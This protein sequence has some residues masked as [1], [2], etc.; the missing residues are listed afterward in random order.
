MNRAEVILKRSQVSL[1]NY[2]MPSAVMTR[3]DILRDLRQLGVSDGDMLMVH[4]SMK[5]IGFVV[6]G[7][8]TLLDS[9]V[10]AVGPRGTLAM[11][12]FSGSLTD[13]ATW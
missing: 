9:I 11:P 5:A 1:P 13:P 12:A 6:G 10:E 7:V 8:R 4:A 3:D 2:E